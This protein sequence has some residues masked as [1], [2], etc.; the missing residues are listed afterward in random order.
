[1]FSR[2]VVDFSSMITLDKYF[3]LGKN[4]IKLI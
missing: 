1:M 4:G 2:G 3:S